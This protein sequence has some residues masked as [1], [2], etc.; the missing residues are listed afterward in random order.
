MW[1][2][3]YNRVKCGWELLSC[4]EFILETN[5]IISS[6]LRIAVIIHTDKQSSATI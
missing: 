6:Y 3:R 4:G 5:A 1:E 2:I